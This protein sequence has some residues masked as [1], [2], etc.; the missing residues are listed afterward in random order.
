MIFSKRYFIQLT[1]FAPAGS[2][3]APDER[4]IVL[5]HNKTVNK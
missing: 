4:L 3:V 1:R 2:I 5:N